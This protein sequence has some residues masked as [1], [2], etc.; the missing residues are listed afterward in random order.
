MFEE[1]FLKSIVKGIGKSTGTMIVLGIVCGGAW[2]A[3]LLKKT[4][5]TK[6]QSKETKETKETQTVQ[7]EPVNQS[8]NEKEDDI[9]HMNI[10]KPRYQYFLQ[11]ENKYKD[12]FNKL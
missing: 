8:D 7:M 10:Q 1:V 12:I 5:K 4:T 6:K 2:Y 11:N 3:S 9:E